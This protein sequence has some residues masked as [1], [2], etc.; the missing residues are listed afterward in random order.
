[1]SAQLLFCRVLLPENVQNRAQHS[2]VVHIKHFF[3]GVWLES[4]WCN[5]SIVLTRLHL[6]RIP[7]LL[8]QRDQISMRLLITQ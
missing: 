2:S 3:P 8:Y 5:H 7:V 4:K 6:G 1:M